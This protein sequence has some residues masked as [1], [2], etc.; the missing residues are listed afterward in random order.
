MRL[1][2]LAQPGNKDVITDPFELEV[3]D[4][5]SR[6][7]SKGD[8]GSRMRQVIGKI[9]LA[10]VK[11]QPKDEKFAVECFKECIASSDWEIAQQVCH[12]AAL[13]GPKTNPLMSLDANYRSWHL[14]R[15]PSLTYAST[16][17]SSSLLSFFM[18]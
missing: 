15:S 3:Y 9:R 13:T 14:R 16:R 1:N 17:S 6:E 10:A 11:T 2:E 5:A 4:H 8:D 18:L 12:V 7:F